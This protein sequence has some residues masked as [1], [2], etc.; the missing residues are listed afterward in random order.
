[1]NNKMI[2]TI[3]GQVSSGKTTLAEKIFWKFVL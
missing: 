3:V 2:I 1:M